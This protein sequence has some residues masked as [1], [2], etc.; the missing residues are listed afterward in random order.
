MKKSYT[1][2]LFACVI[3]VMFSCQKGYNQKSAIVKTKLLFEDSGSKNWKDKWMLD[4]EKSEVINSRNGMELIAGPEHGNDSSHTVLWTKQIFEGNILIEYD[5]T[6]TDT[7]TRCVNI[8]YFHATGKG[9]SEYPS[10]IA[11]WNEKR[12]VPHMS[13]YFNN[14]KTY[15]I[16][17]AA[18]AAKEYSGDNDYIRLRRYNPTKEGLGGTDI[19]GDH[20]VTG[21][22]KTGVTYRI[23]V[24]KYQNQIEM[25][26][27]NKRNVSDHLICKWDVSAYPSYELGRIGL[28]HMYTRNAIY[29]NFKVWEIK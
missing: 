27:E 9:D 16:S 11:L 22:F 4:G 20:F 15:H 6:R 3:L 23:K 24:L 8:L 1:Y 26:I 28:R 14:M 12:N 17:Y 5:Y 7:T 13:T 25:H 19:A 21:L 2:F 18:F 10:D 29:K